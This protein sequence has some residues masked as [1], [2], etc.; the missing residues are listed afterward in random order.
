M[1]A[2]DLSP[3]F[4]KAIA[5]SHRIFASGS[6]KSN[7][8]VGID[9]LLPIFPKAIVEANRSSTISDLLIT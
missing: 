8:S 6:S 7:L 2:P 9:A 1:F 5:A 4:P 3:I